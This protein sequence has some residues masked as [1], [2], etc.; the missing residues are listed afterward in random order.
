MEGQPP[1]SPII[2]V[3]P[4]TI[5][6]NSTPNIEKFRSLIDQRIRI[7]IS[8][9]RFFCGSFVCV[10]KGKNFVLSDATETQSR[11]EDDGPHITERQIGLLTIPGRYIQKVEA[12][13][14][15]VEEMNHITTAA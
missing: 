7:T 5:E 10:D 6:N 14:T 12:L 3:K 11:N 2:T 9:G 15:D 4:L 1:S 13:R 8:D